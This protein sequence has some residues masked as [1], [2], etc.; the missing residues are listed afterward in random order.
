MTIEDAVKLINEK[1][2]DNKPKRWI[3]DP[4]AYTLYEV[5]KIADSKEVYSPSYATVHPTTNADRIRAMSDIELAKWVCSVHG[6]CPQFCPMQSDCDGEDCDG[7]WLDWLK[8]EVDSDQ[9]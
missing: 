8:Q 5:W 2:V 7:E 3:H 9:T 6:S 1:Y 4:V